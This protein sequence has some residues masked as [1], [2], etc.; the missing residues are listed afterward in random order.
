MKFAAKQINE[1][2]TVLPL[3][4]EVI[5]EV[6][7]RV[8]EDGQDFSSLSGR[9]ADQLKDGDW[10]QVAMIHDDDTSVHVS[11]LGQDGAL[12]GV[13]VLLVD[14]EATVLANLVCDAS[15]EKI[16]ELA[17]VITKIGLNTGLRKELQRFFEQVN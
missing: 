10:Q 11:L 17:N 13:F 5:R 9:F 7:V 4:K 16:E 14:G 15:P 12:R 6:R 8:Y 3:A 1:I 2:R